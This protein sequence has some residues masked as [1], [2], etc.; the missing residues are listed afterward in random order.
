MFQMDLEC[1]EA[2]ESFREP[3]FCEEIVIGEKPSD[4][5][6]DCRICGLRFVSKG[7]FTK[8]LKREHEKKIIYE[9]IDENFKIRRTIQKE[10]YAPPS[11][12]KVI[13]ND[14][15]AV[16]DEEEEES[17]EEAIAEFREEAIEEVEEDQISAEDEPVGIYITDVNSICE[18][19]K[20]DPIKCDHCSEDFENEVHLVDHLTALDCLPF[21]PFRCSKCSLTFDTIN[22]KRVRAFIN[23]GIPLKMGNQSPLRFCGIVILPFFFFFAHFFR[24][25]WQIMNSTF[26]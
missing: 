16:E 18:E 11:K 5:P 19:I 17:K 15:K 6:F 1:E 9:A 21:P 2:L 7:L 4:L 26:F 25:N 22:L 10:H 20:K 24:K 14:G 12:V 8:H 23:R 3:E 13:I